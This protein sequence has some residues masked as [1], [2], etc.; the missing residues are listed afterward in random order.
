MAK[1]GVKTILNDALIMQ[2]REQVLKGCEIR[3]TARNIGI[4]EQTLYD[5]RRNN[6]LNLTDK[7]NTWELQRNLKQAEDFSKHLMELPSYEDEKLNTKLLSIKQREAE[8]LRSTLLIAR[9]KY[10]KRDS[11][12]KQGNVQINILNYTSKEDTHIVPVVHEV[13][14]EEK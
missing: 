1:R 12:E 3:E 13:K 7:W 4:N 5:W 14:E 9:N 8:F 6:Y 10:D 2:L 11:G